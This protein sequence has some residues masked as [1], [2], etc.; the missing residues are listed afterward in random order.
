MIVQLIKP[1]PS[2]SGRTDLPALATEQH[3]TIEV[4]DAFNLNGLEENPYTF[5]STPPI[6]TEEGETYRYKPQ[7]LG[8]D[9]ESE[10]IVVFGPD[11]M[12]VD[13]NNEI[14]WEVPADA[15]GSYVWLRGFTSDGFPVE[16]FY[17]LHVHLSWNRLPQ[18]LRITQVD[19]YEEDVMVNW[20]GSAPQVVIQRTDSLENPQWKTISDPIDRHTVNLYADREV[21]GSSGYYR[22]VETQLETGQ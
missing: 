19:R 22:V 9:E 6:Y 4:L 11:D 13:E 7:I 16:Q 14:V 15:P 21:A 12:Y 17:F 20:I 3:F 10:F 18:E 5:I 2:L 1:Y 8:P